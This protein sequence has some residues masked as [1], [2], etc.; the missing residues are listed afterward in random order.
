MKCYLCSS[1]QFLI[2][3]GKVRDAPEMQ[4]LQCKGCGLVAL[5]NSDH[6]NEGFYENSGMHGIDPTPMDVWLKATQW[7]DKR[8]LEMCKTMLPNKRLLDFGCGAAGFLRGAQGLASEVIGIELEARVREHWAGQ[9]KIVPAIEMAEGEYDLIT[10]FHVVEHLA[11]PRAVL[12]RLANLLKLGGRMVVEVPNAEDILLTLY[13]CN[14]F[15]HFTYWSQHLFL[16]NATTI[17]ILARQAGLHVKAVQHYQRYPLSN[18]LHWLCLGKP[19]GHEN[20]SFLN[21]PDIVSAYSN[22][23]AAV[24]KT[25]TLVIHLE[26]FE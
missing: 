2:R 10:A 26:R 15:Q 5:N 1:S 22:V 19:G 9:I 21:T 8:R 6:I 20:W 7:D 23:L 11:D 14:A 17:E 13:D 24:G 4:I 25:D 12:A 3:N 18:H 16:F